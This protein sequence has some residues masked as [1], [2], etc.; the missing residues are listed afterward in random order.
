MNYTGRN[1]L[2]TS[3][4]R[5]FADE[6][7]SVGTGQLSQLIQNRWKEYDFFVNAHLP[8]EL[9]RRGF[10]DDFDLPGYLFR[11]DGL[12]IWEALGEF[13]TNFVNE[14]YLTD[15]HVANDIVLQL[16]ANEMTDPSKAAVPGFPTAFQDTST[17]ALTMQCLWWVVGALHIV[18]NASHFDV[19]PSPLENWIY[20]SLVLAHICVLFVS[21]VVL[22]LPTRQAF[23]F[24]NEHGNV[25]GKRA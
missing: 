24:E 22:L 17:L 23:E 12:K 10:D 18:H 13:T 11:E 25:Q 2:F 16:W 19:S 21:C 6:F 9:R 5:S 1:M 7:I 3:Y 8:N 4:P 15:Q 20:L 14:V